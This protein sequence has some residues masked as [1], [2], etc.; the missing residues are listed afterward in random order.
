MLR[1]YLARHGQDEDN[2]NGIL[3]GQRDMPL[4]S[5]GEKQVFE[6][7][8]K[9]KKSRIKF[10]KIYTSPLQRAYKTSR[11]ISGSLGMEDPKKLPK[12]I[13]RDFGVMTGKPHS[14]IAEIC[15][16]YILKTKTV[17]YFLS[18][19]GAETFPQLVKRGRDIL[20]YIKVIH[21][22]GNILFVTHGDIGKM[23]YAAY[24][25]LEW[26]R[27]LKMFHFGNSDL[28]LLAENSPMAKSHVVK[29]K[30]YN[31]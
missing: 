17:T 4:T 5:L 9:I 3:N 1:I 18:P 15:S 26:R 30:Q 19:D 24:Y 6:L 12:L 14:Q 20:D 25:K 11:I 31:L 16:P 10:D 27:V 13:E 28:I 22:H 2:A 7:A 8:D 21:K 29:I 23:I